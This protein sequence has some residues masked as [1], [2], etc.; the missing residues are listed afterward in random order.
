MVF[1]PFAVCM[2]VMVGFTAIVTVFHVYVLAP[3]AVKVLLSPEQMIKYPNMLMVGLCIAMEIVFVMAQ[4][5]FVL[6]QITE[7]VVF[8]V[9]G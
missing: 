5:L 9:G 6:V 8:K 7:R 1:V 2:V 3:E 4:L